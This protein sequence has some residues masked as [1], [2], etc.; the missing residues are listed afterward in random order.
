MFE[1]KWYMGDEAVNTLKKLNISTTMEDAFA[2]HVF[3]T[4]KNDGSM[5]ALGSAYPNRE[6]GDICIER[7][8][9]MPKY[10]ATIFDEFVLRMLLYKFQEIANQNIY[11]WA[12]ESEQKLIARFGFS[13]ANEKHGELLK[14]QVNTSSIIWPKECDCQE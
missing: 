4:Q 6:S 14:M 7:I 1:A 5:I 11:M 13:A 3:V 8:V 9:K 10:E 2:V 12:N